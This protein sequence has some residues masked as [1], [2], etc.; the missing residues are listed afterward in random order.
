[1]TW[2]KRLAVTALAGLAVTGCGGVPT[3]S[4]PGTASVSAPSILPKGATETAVSTATSK[5]DTSCNGGEPTASLAPTGPL[6]APGHTPPGSYMAAI[7][8]RGTLIAGVDQNTLLWGYRNSQGQEAGFDI[9][10]VK[11]IAQAIFGDSNPS[12]LEFVIVPNAD[13]QKDVANGTVDLVAETMTITCDRQ[14]G[15]DKQPAVDFSS[16]YYDAHQEILVPRNSAIT[17]IAG[18]AG[19]SVCAPTKS[20]SLTNLAQRVP[21]AK[22]WSVAN[23][24]DCLVMLQQGQVE[25]ISTD[26]TILQGLAFQDK[27][28]KIL[29]DQTLSDEP[30]GMAISQAHPDF[31]RFVNAVLAQERADGVWQS[32]W[33]KTLGPTLGTAPP[34]P[35]KARYRG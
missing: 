20:T 12:H 22:L 16:E 9:E 28:V 8:E 32:I 31:T 30:Y 27:N 1:M 24:T 23:F 26:D 15:R 21:S 29:S 10:M 11:Q 34:A 14:D 6:P 19:R 18:L 25:A 33:Q 4:T 13:R 7:A 5:P 35:P 2:A 3:S 17:S